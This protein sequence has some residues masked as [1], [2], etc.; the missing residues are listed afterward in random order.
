MY[1]YEKGR[2]GGGGG[3][4]TYDLNQNTSWC[5]VCVSMR[6]GDGGGLHMI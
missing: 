1:V 5:C 2:R 3:G 4:V 6:G